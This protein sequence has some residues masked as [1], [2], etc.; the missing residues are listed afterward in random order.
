MKKVKMILTATLVF[1]VVGGALAF[2]PFQNHKLFTPD[3]NGACT[4][5]QDGVIID[6]GSSSTET[7]ATTSGGTCQTVHFSTV[8]D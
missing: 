4:V 1:A 6:N 7:A 3:E 2:K 5:E 8:T